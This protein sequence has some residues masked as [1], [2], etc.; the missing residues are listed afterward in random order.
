MEEARLMKRIFQEIFHAF[1]KRSAD[2]ATLHGK[3]QVL[4]QFRTNLSIDTDFSAFRKY[5]KQRG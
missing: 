5:K 3:M 4:V 2:V 1:L